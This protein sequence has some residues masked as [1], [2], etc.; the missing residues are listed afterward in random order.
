MKNGNRVAISPIRKDLVTGISGRWFLCSPVI[1]DV[2]KAADS[3]V[4]TGIDCSGPIEI[5][6]K[7]RID[8]QNGTHEVKRYIQGCLCRQIAAYGGLSDGCP[9]RLSR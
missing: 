7:R 9:R 1:E 4:K 3:D 5:W 6:Y 2:L 8:D